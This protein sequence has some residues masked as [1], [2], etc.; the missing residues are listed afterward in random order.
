MSEDSP[1]LFAVGQSPVLKALNE[2]HKMIALMDIQGFSA[3]EIA[4]H[5]DMTQSWVS[6]IKTSDAYRAYLGQLRKITNEKVI[7][8]EAEDMRTLK[9]QIK[10]GV[11]VLKDVMHN[12]ERDSD[13]VSAAKAIIEHGRRVAGLDKTVIGFDAKKAEGMDTAALL[14]LI[15]ERMPSGETSTGDTG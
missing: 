2:K 9:T 8:A 11:A 3:R 4:A 5:V 12:A 6:S 15:G 10:D 13:K 14:N 7:E 1:K